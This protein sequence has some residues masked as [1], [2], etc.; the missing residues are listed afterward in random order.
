MQEGQQQNY[1]E[2]TLEALIIRQKD[3]SLK[4]AYKKT[5][6]AKFSEKRRF[7]ENL[8]TSYFL[9]KTVLRFTLFPSY[10]RY[11]H[12]TRRYFPKLL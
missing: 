12:F 4:G 9:I 7:S 8:G 3:E 10:R 2:Y 5:K 6:H 1:I 11:Y